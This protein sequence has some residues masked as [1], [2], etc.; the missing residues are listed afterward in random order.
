[1]WKTFPAAADHLL[2]YIKKKG[3]KQVIRAGKGCGQRGFF[4]GHRCEPFVEKWITEGKTCGGRRRP[5]GGGASAR[6]KLCRN[7]QKLST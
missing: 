4:C 3:K 1:M 5:Y 6:T 7:K 2:Y